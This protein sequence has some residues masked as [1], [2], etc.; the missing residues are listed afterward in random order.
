L[1]QTLKNAIE[2][3]AGIDVHIIEHQGVVLFALEK[4]AYSKLDFVD[5]ILIGYSKMEGYDIF[6]FDKKLKNNL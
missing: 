6:T 2:S 4:Y 3:V 5:C 1:I